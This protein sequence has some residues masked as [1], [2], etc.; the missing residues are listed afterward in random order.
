[1]GYQN[2]EI[3]L[4]KQMQDSHQLIP[5]LSDY[6]VVSVFL[7]CGYVTLP[8]TNH[9]NDIAYV[10]FNIFLRPFSQK[11]KFL[12]PT[13]V[14]APLVYEWELLKFPCECL[15]NLLIPV[16]TINNINAGQMEDLPVVQQTI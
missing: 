3:E 12:T 5:T 7:D 6:I 1:M 15:K 4:K 11:H 14:H 9:Y 8:A 16:T 2:Q 10:T 13:E